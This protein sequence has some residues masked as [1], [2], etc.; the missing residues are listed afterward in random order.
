MCP[1]GDLSV[2][3]QAAHEAHPHLGY[4]GDIH[5]PQAP[6]AQANF[7]IIGSRL[8]KMNLGLTKYLC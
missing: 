4:P 2:A 3:F 5:P 6:E 1:L 8:L 7:G